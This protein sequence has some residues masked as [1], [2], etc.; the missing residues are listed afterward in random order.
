MSAQSI[1]KPNYN[2]T[3]RGFTLVELLIVIVVL[4]ILATITIVAY[5][6]VQNR[7][8]VAALQATVTQATNKLGLY[9]TDNGNYPAD[10][11][12]AGLSNLNSGG[13]TV[14]YVP[15]T[16]ASNRQGYCIEVANGSN[17]YFGSDITPTPQVGGCGGGTVN[18]NSC[19]AGYIAVP[20]NT[21]LNPSE[22]NGFCVMKYEA[23]NNGSGTAVSVA[24]GSPWVSITQ[25]STISTSAAACAGCHLITDQEWM[26]IAANVLSVPDNWSGNAVGNGFIY[27][28]HNDDVPANTLVADS[29]DTNGYTGTGNSSPS[30]QRR[31]LTLT[32]GEVI[33]DFAGNAWEWDS[34]TITGTQPGL[35]S[36]SAYAWKEWNNPSLIMT[37][38]P[39]TSRP[40]AI[41]AQAASWSSAQGIGML[42]SKSTET[43]T[44]AYIRGGYFG[45]AA[46]SQATGVLALSLQVQP[47]FTFLGIGFRVAK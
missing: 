33:W 1:V 37:G 3:Q 8:R 7:A 25:T 43:A 10:L 16:S 46:N 14:N 20:A 31:T 39:A 41:S 12:T 23:K 44:N 38:L 4:A 29:S 28:G 30:N 17:N 22:P 11:T 24:S 26:T 5:N 18:G 15:Y 13:N 36:E 19:P 40:S 21:T 27:S 2:D 32:N 35:A 42:Y 6:G 45:D 47:S 34:G 9:F